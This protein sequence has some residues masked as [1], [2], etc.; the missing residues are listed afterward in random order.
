MRR[1]ISFSDIDRIGARKLGC[2]A[3]LAIVL[4]AAACAERSSNGS[5]ATPTTAPDE[6]G[7]H[8]A[9]ASMTPRIPRYRAKPINRR[10]LP[11]TLDPASFTTG[12][13]AH[14]YRVAKEIPEV[15]AEQPCYC[16]CDSGF[17]HGSLLDCHVDDHSAGCVVCLKESLLA[18]QLHRQGKT[19]EDIREA[20]VRGDWR[21]VELK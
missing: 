9:V 3:F 18:E 19:T 8:G 5:Q 6:H 15:L 2:L 10:E 4:L 16:Y 11:A 21:N 1:V 14:S 17:G 13:I 20:I 12:Y 7:G